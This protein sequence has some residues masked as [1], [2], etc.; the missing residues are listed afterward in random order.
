MERGIKHV[1]ETMLL[2]MRLSHDFVVV[3]IDL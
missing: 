2:K 3:N 1:E